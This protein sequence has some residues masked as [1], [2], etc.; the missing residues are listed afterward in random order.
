IREEPINCYDKE[1]VNPA[2]RLWFLQEKYN[3]HNQ[4]IDFY[5]GIGVAGELLFI[6]MFILSLVQYKKQFFPTAFITTLFFFGVIECY[7]YR[8]MGSY[9]FGLI[10]IL[11]LFENFNLQVEKNSKKNE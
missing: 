9:Y 2:R 7:F 3:T 8:Q 4:Y 11:I 1:I 6:S 10:L 5:L